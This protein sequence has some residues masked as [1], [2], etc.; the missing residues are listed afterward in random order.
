MQT[1]EKMQELGRRVK[2][3]LPEG[4]GYALFVFPHGQ[5]GAANY[6]SDS[7]RADVIEAVKGFV[8]RNEEGRVVDTPSGN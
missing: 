2:A 7:E 1:K 8:K 6:V 5:L 3:Q 4:T